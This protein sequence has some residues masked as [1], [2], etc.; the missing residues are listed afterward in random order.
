LARGGRGGCRDQTNRTV[1]STI[2][3]GANHD[4]HSHRGNPPEGRKKKAHS[5][6]WFKG[7]KEGDTSN[8]REMEKLKKTARNARKGKR[9]SGTTLIKSKKRRSK[10]R[11]KRK[12]KK[13]NNASR[14]PSTK[15]KKRNIS[16]HWARKLCLEKR[17]RK[18][19]GKKNRKNKT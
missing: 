2:Q 11:Q 5:V 19:A 13:G 3:T 18:E 9:R 14:T 8:L 15:K 1:T 12:A 6:S 17:Q 7:R 10:T 4:L 16:N